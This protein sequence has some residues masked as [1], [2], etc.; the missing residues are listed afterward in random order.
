MQLFQFAICANPSVDQY[1]NN[2]NGNYH[3]LQF[4]S[5]DRTN[6][7]FISFDDLKVSIKKG[8]SINN[9]FQWYMNNKTYSASRNKERTEYPRIRAAR[10]TELSPKIKEAI[11]D[12]DFP[13]YYNIIQHE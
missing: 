10:L 5:I 4:A 3:L 2:C 11:K 12:K 8:N 9:S 1:R 6:N 13:S 7:V